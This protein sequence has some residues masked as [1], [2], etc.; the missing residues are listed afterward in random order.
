[1]IC[2]ICGLENEYFARSIILAK[3]EIKY[4]RCL[5]CGF[6]QTEE[7]YWLEEA[8]QNPITD[9]DTGLVSRNIA[10]AKITRRLLFFLLKPRQNS[11]YIDY[12]GGYGLFVRLMR[13]YGYPFLWYDKY[14]PNLFA[15][16]LEADLND[17]FDLMTAFEL[18]EHL[19]DPK[20]EIDWILQHTDNFLF[21]T[22]FLPNS[23]P[24]PG[25]WWYYGVEHGQHISFYSKRSLLILARNNGMNFYTNNTNLHLITK[26]KLSGWLFHFLCNTWES[27]ILLRGLLKI[28]H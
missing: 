9:Y 23:T 16:G 18:L 21:S 5:N 19:P 12:G 8:Y 3:Y 27:E 17:R 11:V 15:K 4:F 22:E 26:M 25:E 28:K 13:D 14:T 2:N 6:V 1:M 24:Q 7:P 10:L 20:S